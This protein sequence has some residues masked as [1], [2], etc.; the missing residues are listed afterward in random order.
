MA[1]NS[2]TLAVITPGSLLDRGSHIGECHATVWRMPRNRLANA[3]QPFGE[4]HATVWRM[5][6]NRVANAM[7]PC[8]ERHATVWRT[9]QFVY[10]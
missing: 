7:Q 4:R 2:I 8:G 5:P 9:P 6:C 1:K 10:G 3:M